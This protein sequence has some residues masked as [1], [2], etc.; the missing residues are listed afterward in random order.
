MEFPCSTI[1]SLETEVLSNFPWNN[2]GYFEKNLPNILGE[3][4]VQNQHEQICQNHCK[5]YFSY[6]HQMIVLI[7]Q[8]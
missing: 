7:N 5:H 3:K 6:F 4:H 2:S 8:L 1:N